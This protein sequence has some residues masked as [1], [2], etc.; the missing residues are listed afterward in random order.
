MSH[1][2][3]VSVVVPA[4]NSDEFVG[5]AVESALSQTYPPIEV[6]VVDDGST[7]DTARVLELLGDRIK[8]VR[9]ENAGVAAARNTGIAVAR[10]ELFAFLDAD[11]AWVP[12]KL[13]RQ[14]QIHAQ[15]PQIGLT[16]CGLVEVDRRLKPLRE[17][18]AGL[19]GDGVYLK[20]LYGQG[21]RLHASGST[22]MVSRAAIDAV[23]DFDASLP[24]SED[25]ELMYRV[26]KQFRV[27]FV[28]EP[29]V[30][31]R[32]HPDNAHRNIPR[33]ERSMMLALGK[34]F[35]SGG[36]DVRALRRPTYATV[37]GWLAGSYWEA[38]DRRS[39]LRHAAAAAWLQ[40]SMLKRF[41]GFPTRRLAR[42]RNQRNASADRLC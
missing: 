23:G 37:H 9:Q 21:D 39:F 35:D 31:Y 38:G 14:V 26:A 24:P 17:R 2:S 33:Q 28:P 11:D 41:A 32:Q 25:W 10:G 5:E 4:Y 1:G 42:Q 15:N 3:T 29:L 30:L 13:D 22:M 7:D 18:L 8:L 20:M 27:G 16:H 40:P 34:V 6:I 36:P 12:E 19:E